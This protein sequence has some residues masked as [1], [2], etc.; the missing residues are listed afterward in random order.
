MVFES[1]VCV[2]GGKENRYKRKFDKGRTFCWYSGD[3]KS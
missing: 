3:L 2:F 1:S